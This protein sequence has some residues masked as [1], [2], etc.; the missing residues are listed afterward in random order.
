MTVQYQPE[1]RTVDFSID[2]ERTYTVVVPWPFDQPTARKYHNGLPNREVVS[3]GPIVEGLAMKDPTVLPLLSRQLLVSAG[4]EGGLKFDRRYPEP[5][6]QWK[7]WTSH[8][9]ERQRQKQP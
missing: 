2:P 9:Q 4:T 1:D 6:P 3:T 8:F 5:D 7:L